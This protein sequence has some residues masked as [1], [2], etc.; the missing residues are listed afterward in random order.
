LKKTVPSAK[1]ISVRDSKNLLLIKEKR[2]PNMN[3]KQNEKIMQ[4]TEKTLVV[5][6]DIAKE[7]HY[8]RAFNYRGLELARVYSFSNNHAGFESFRQWCEEIMRKNNL[9]KL[10]IGMEP[11]G[12]YWFTFAEYCRDNDMKIVLVNPFHVKRSK[13]LDDNSPTKTDRKDPKTIAKLV[14]DG[15]FVEIYIPTGVY[16]ELRGVLRM[17][18]HVNGCKSVVDNKIQQWLDI[19]FPEFMEVFGSWNCKSAMITLRQFPL[20]SMIVELGE[21]KVLEEWKKE[22][23]QG[24]GKK[25][26]RKLVETAQKSI[27]SKE[28]LKMAVRELQYLISEYDVYVKQMEEIKT[29]MENLLEQ[30]PAAKKALK[31]KGM[32]V[33]TVAGIIAEIGEFSRFEDARQIQ[34]YA[35]LNLVENSSGKHKGETTISKRG[36]KRLRSLLFRVI[37]PMVANNPEF[38]ELHQ[39]YTK[40]KENPLKKKQSLILL[41]C[42]LIRILYA[43]MTKDVEYDG[44]KLMKDIKRASKEAA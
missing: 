15:R 12:H 28:G 37:M 8:Y 27:G 17:Y 23:K 6:V 32:G 22:I 29:E 9:D 14:I 35:G 33:V 5:G 19:Y 7:T 16:A 31:I 1:I 3:Y 44:S 21:T 38:K 10:I 24:V 42:K 36:R 18:D 39:Y 11:T 30:I 26:V 4:V 34:K 13:E 40:R 41:C 43:I 25:R 20:P 2:A